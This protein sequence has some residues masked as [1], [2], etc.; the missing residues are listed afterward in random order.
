MNIELKST[1]FLIDENIT[2]DLKLIFF[3]ETVEIRKRKDA[4]DE[5]ISKRIFESSVDT[6]K[7]FRLINKLRV[8]LEDCWD[9]QDE[10]MNINRMCKADL[11]WYAQDYE[12]IAKAAIKAQELNAER[13]K[14]I[15]QID[16]LLGESEFSQLEKSYA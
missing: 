9:A 4:L 7:L 5:V 15:R 2:T 11:K 12:N 6:K 8:V 13:N 1:G 16:A 10:I 14:L 3:G